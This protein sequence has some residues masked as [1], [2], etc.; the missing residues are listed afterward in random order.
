MSP[1]DLR[2]VDVLTDQIVT[3]RSAEFAHA[4][5][6]GFLRR[7]LVFLGEARLDI[8]HEP[9]GERNSRLVRAARAGQKNGPNRN[10]FVRVLA[11]FL[12]DLFK[13][14]SSGHDAIFRPCAS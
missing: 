1:V 12:G 6:I 14:P 3:I 11:D 5:R 13:C 7:P 2:F 9:A 10:A 8:V 4:D